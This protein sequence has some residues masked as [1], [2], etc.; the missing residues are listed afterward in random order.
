[1]ATTIWQDISPF[2]SKDTYELNGYRKTS[3]TTFDKPTSKAAT[4]KGYNASG[5]STP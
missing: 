3:L 2:Y 5:S 1:M 4:K